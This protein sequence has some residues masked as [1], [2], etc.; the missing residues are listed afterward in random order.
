MDNE[1]EFTYENVLED[2]GDDVGDLGFADE[3]AAPLPGGEEEFADEPEP[4]VCVRA[5][6][7]RPGTVS[8]RIGRSFSMYARCA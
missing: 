8:P 4:A 5:P 7:R 3:E 6:R 2:Y 1:D